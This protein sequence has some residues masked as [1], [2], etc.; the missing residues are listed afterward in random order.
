M[1][2]IYNQNK[3]N[4]VRSL[5]GVDLQIFPHEYVIIHGP[6]GCGKSTLMYSIG[7]FQIPTEGE[8]VVEGK[9]ISKM[10]PREIVDLHQTG[11]GMIFQA[12]Y[13]IP[14][15]TILDNVCLPRTFMGESLKTRR[16]AGMTLLQ[17][18]GI[19][20]QAYKFPSQLSGG[21]KQR[22]AIA[23]SLVN[24]PQIILADEPVGNLDSESAKNVLQILK[25][26]N[27]IDKKTIIMVTHNPEHLY[28]GDRIIHM[29]DGK[30]VGEEVNKEKRPL[31]FFEKARKEAIGEKKISDVKDEKSLLEGNT[32]EKIDVPNELKLLMRMFRGLD[33]SQLGALLV[34]FKAKQLLSH[35]LAELND[36][37]LSSAEN[38]LKELLFKNIK[39]NDLPSKL[40]M[41]FEEGGSN[42]NKSRAKSFSTR[43]ASILEQVD[44]QTDIGEKNKDEAVLHMCG[45][46]Q[47]M[48]HLHLDETASARFHSFMKLRFDNKI[49]GIELK[50][51]LDLAKL[52]G[53][54]GLNK[55][56]AEKLVREMEVIMLLKYKD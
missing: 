24:N 19:M 10:T 37:Q 21:Q 26:L 30:I 3:S 49:D 12:F 35:A 23:R 18:F 43:I 46:L 22:V 17:R 44:F 7:G 33:N 25:N 4:E 39:I 36:E 1:K 56:T 28:Y 2:I 13:L 34:P 11:V 40:D 16:E 5:D 47:S 9:K 31:D 29:K 45:Y 8:V 27:E 52:L 15:L 53:G 32:Q 51:Q 14:T 38:F 55:V 42:W 48:F 54:V 6:S 41:S 20:E 50:K